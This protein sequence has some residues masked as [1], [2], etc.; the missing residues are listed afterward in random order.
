MSWI[1]NVST[2]P[3]TSVSIYCVHHNIT[4]F[5]LLAFNWNIHG[6]KWPFMCWC[7]VKKLLTHSVQT[8]VICSV[9]AMALWHHSV[10]GWWKCPLCRILQLHH[11][12][13]KNWLR[14]LSFLLCCSPNLEPY[15]YCYQSLTITW[16]LQTSPQNLLPC[17]T[18]TF[19]PPSDSSTPLI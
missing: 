4:Q 6:T 9:V 18:I 2:Y 8:E 12:E 15:T 17:L 13:D 19:S 10:T 14:T 1:H 7:A 5:R 16:L 11:S 3:I